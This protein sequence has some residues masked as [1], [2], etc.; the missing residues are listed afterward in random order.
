MHKTVG[1]SVVAAVTLKPLV[2]NANQGEVIIAPVFTAFANP[3]PFSLQYAKGEWDDKLL[4]AV[5]DH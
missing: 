1:D 2:A 5:R 3:M 4:P